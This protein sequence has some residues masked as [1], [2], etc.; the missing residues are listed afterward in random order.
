MDYGLEI[1]RGAS[2][3]EMSEKTPMESP[4][5]SDQAQ[6][7]RSRI[8]AIM[9]K[10]GFVAYPFEFWHYSSGDAYC[11]YIN[12]TG[13]PASYGPVHMDP[14]SDMVRQIENPNEPIRNLEVL[15][16]MLNRL[17]DVRENQ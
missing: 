3:L 6:M 14:L 12:K 1:D 10:Y 15:H 2:Y 5:V 11:E 4:H 16:A 17:S 8:T 7:N 9:A 13:R